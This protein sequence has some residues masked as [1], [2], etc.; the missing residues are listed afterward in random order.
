MEN[1]MSKSSHGC[2]EKSW[3]IYTMFL[4]PININIY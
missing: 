1:L 4:G 2:E 3:N